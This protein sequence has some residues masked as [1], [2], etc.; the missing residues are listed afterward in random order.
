MQPVAMRKQFVGMAR[1]EIM[2]KLMR[3]GKPDEAFVLD[4]Q[5]VSDAK[6]IA[7]AHDRCPLYSS[8]WAAVFFR[9]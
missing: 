7:H 3:H 6:R 5:G 8:R 2:P 4:V 9:K 1:Q